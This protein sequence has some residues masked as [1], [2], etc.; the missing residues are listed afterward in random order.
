MRLLLLFLIVPI[1]EIVVFIGVNNYIGLIYTIILVLLTAT[2]G[3]LIVKRQGFQ[4]IS[5]FRNQIVTQTG[6]PLILLINGFIILVAGV[7]LLTPGFITDS[8]GFSLLIPK[9]R[10]VIIREA[11]KRIKPQNTDFKV[12]YEINL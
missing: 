4:A 9:L 6:N 5:N 7:L 10:D 11:I 3:T 12:D 8:F 2:I 1:L